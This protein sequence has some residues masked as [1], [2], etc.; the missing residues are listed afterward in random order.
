MRIRWLCIILVMVVV[1][2]ERSPLPTGNGTVESKPQGE[3]VSIEGSQHEQ[4]EKVLARNLRDVPVGRRYRAVSQKADDLW[5]LIDGLLS[6]DTEYVILVTAKFQQELESEMREIEIPRKTVDVGS[7]YISRDGTR[8]HRATKEVAE[9]AAKEERSI[10]EAQEYR[11]Q[12][13]HFLSRYPNRL[14][15]PFMKTLWGK[16]PP[17]TQSR[18][19]KNIIEVLGRPPKW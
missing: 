4:I 9:K 2:C 10:G 7:L 12:L 16:L 14:D 13:E 1:G 3:V 17:D 15:S 5:R 19:R 11:K 18:L 8:Y 6:N